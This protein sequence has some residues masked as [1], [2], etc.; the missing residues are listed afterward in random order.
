[1][2][3]K[4]IGL[5]AILIALGVVVTLISDSGSVTSLIPA[6]IGAVFLVLGLVGN[7]KEDLN[8]H[9]M[10]GA[11]ALSLIAILGS[12]G[13]LIGRSSGGWAAFAQIAT[14]VLCAAF[15]V[16]AI[17]SFRAARIAR[18]AQEAAAT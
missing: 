15:L 7:A 12:L 3:V 8:H 13:S 11:A 14:T 4:A 18:E 2:A 6:F 17:Q 9:M 16:A 5:G 1:M 10:H